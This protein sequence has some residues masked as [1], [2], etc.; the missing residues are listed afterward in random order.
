MI[1]AFRME[2]IKSIK[3]ATSNIKIMLWIIA[4]VVVLADITII[5]AR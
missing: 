4:A 5:L 1:R 2:T 3:K